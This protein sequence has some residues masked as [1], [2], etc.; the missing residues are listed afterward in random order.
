MFFIRFNFA[1]DSVDQHSKMMQVLKYT[2]IYVTDGDAIIKVH[3]STLMV[4]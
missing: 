1:P 2:V 4:L 3:C